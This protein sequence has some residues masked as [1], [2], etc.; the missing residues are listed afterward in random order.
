[1]NNYTPEVIFEARYESLSQDREWLSYIA[2]RVYA[3]VLRE[4][5]PRG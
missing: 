5:Y 1:M 4:K 3:D 2:M